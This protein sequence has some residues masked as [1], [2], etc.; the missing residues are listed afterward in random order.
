MPAEDVKTLGRAETTLRGLSLI[1]AGEASG[2]GKAFHAF[3]P[4]TGESLEPAYHSATPYELDRAAKLAAEAFPVYSRISGRERAAFLR[5]VAAKIEGLVE[6]F[7]VRTVQETA[8]PVARVRGETART[9]GQ[10][11]LFADVIEEGSWVNARIDPALPSR[12][13]LPRPDLRSMLRPVGPVAVFAASNFPLA[14]SVAGGDTASALAA[15]NPVIVKAHSAH[16]GTSELVG[17]AIRES[18]RE[19]GLPEGVFSVVFDA[20]FE[21]GTQLVQH[22][23]IKGVGFTGSRAGGEALMKAAAQRSEPIPFYAEM[24]STNPVFI[25]PGALR[26]RSEQ[27]ASGLAASFT[28]GA[29]QFCTKPGVVILKQDAQAD[30]FARQLRA[31]V[32]KVTDFTLLTSGIQSA[33]ENGARTRTGKARICAEGPKTEAA[34]FRVSAVVFEASAH[35]LVNDPHLA[36]E[37]FGPS[38]VLTRY[39]SDDELLEFAR[40]LDGHLTA[41]VHGTPE[42]LQQNAELL[43]I[44]EG[45]VGRL[46]INGFPTGVEVSHAMVHGGPYPSTSDSRTTSVGTMAIFRFARPVC[47]QGFPDEALPEPLRNANPL[48][49]WRMLDGK[50]TRD[51]IA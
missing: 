10:L 28:L 44:L 22:P 5:T 14:F 19:H 8:L 26:E 7:A 4:A 45:K 24:S 6:S 33:Y 32:E 46:I 41:T 31:N 48:G 29:G 25:L 49:I 34:G 12:Q 42:D 37:L 30:S 11:R 38:T 1:G 18:V 3:N 47:Y 21:I 36:E 35:E 17:N 13:P 2:K 23:E 20:G 50:M 43:Q 27:I 40:G 39:S 15:G 9:S 16:P 51:P